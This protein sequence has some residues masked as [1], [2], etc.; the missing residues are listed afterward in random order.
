[1]SDSKKKRGIW[2]GK[3][4]RAEGCELNQAARDVVLQKLRHDIE[5]LLGLLR[6]AEDAIDRAGA[7]LSI[8]QPAR[9]YGK[10]SLRWWKTAPK[11]AYLEPVIVRWAAQKNGVMTPK[12]AKILKAKESGTF[13]INAKETQECLQI[14]SGLLKRRAEIKSRIATLSKSLR[15]LNGISYYLNNEKERIE[16]LKSRVVLNL[17]EAGYDVEPRLLPPNEGEESR[18]DL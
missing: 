6:E 5:E 17:L 4:G 15:E 13:A 12:R 2:E 3:R 18:P 10:Y 7:V 8:S 14:L 16:A 9:A 11:A 1:M